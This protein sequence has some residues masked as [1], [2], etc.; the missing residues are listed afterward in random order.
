M[1]SEIVFT[2]IAPDGRTA[3]L[4]LT[5]ERGLQLAEQVEDLCPDFLDSDSQLER[6]R[7]TFNWISATAMLRGWATP[8]YSSDPPDLTTMQ[9][10]TFI[11]L[12]ETPSS[13]SSPPTGAS[14]I[15]SQPKVTTFA[16][17]S[18]GFLLR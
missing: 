15:S 16:G 4:T 7:K 9:V 2:H 6:Q 8:V 1:S 13:S 14:G 5:R 11:P 12:S 10:Q 3:S 17:L 18:K